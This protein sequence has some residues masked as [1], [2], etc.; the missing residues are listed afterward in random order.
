MSEVVELLQALIRCDTSNPPGNERPAVDLI[1][2][3]LDAEEIAYEIVEPEPGRANIVA[4]L[5]GD[6]SSR[7]LMLSA[8]LD[9][10]PALDPGWEHPPFGGELHDGYIW[11]RG[12]VD[13]KHMAAMSLVAFCELKRRDVKLKRDVIFA[14]VADEE[15]GGIFGAGYLADKRPELIDAEF[16]LT[17]LGGM[18]VPLNGK[19]LL[20]VQTAQKGYVW[21]TLKAKGQ[22]GHGSRPRAGSA[23]EKLTEAANRLAKEPLS[24]GLTRSAAGFFDA[25]SKLQGPVRGAALQLLKSELTVDAG[26]S[27]IPGERQA[28]FRAMLHN[29]AAVTGLKAGVK[30]NVIPGEACAHVDGRYLPGVSKED[31]LAEVQEIVGPEI[32]IEVF[33]SAPPQE[34]EEHRSVC[35]DAIEKVMKR[36]IPGIVV[37]PYMIPGMTDAKDYA[38]AGIKTYGFAPVK[39]KENEPFADLYHAPNERISAQGVE[40]GLKWLQDVVLELCA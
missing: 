15:A 6:G 10:V 33:D 25:V 24:Y 5:K 37:A 29:T 20:P 1:A 2:A 18:A 35:W 32:E 31:F 17:E 28:S 36:H 14:G 38:R 11:G 21:F 13:M 4:R 9:V 22:A 12:A 3:K 26:L 34:M 40:E 16:C 8:H 23:V 30:V 19:W 7:P 39:L 27:L